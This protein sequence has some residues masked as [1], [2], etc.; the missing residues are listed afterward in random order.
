MRQSLARNT[1]G[2][3]EARGNYRDLPTNT[4]DAIVSGTLHA[5]L[6]AI[7]RLRAPNATVLLSGGAAAALLPHLAAPTR[8]FDQLV[9][10]G[11]ARA[12]ADC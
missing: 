1:A 10:A 3:P 12:A 11:L 5:T 7:A 8:R 2:L 9:L 4:D 6:G